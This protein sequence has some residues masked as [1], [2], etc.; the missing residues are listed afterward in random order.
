MNTAQLLRGALAALMLTGLVVGWSIAGAMA[1]DGAARIA[2]ASVNESILYSG[3][4]DSPDE[5]RENVGLAIAPVPLDVDGLDLAK[6]GLGSY[7]VNAIGGCNECHTN[8]PYAD[9]GDPFLG[10]PKQINA[11]H[12]LAGGNVFGPFVSRNITPIGPE[13]LPAG[14]TYDV[15]SD[16]MR[17][18]TDVRC[19]PGA[20]PPCPLLQ[21]MPWPVL[22]HMS[23]RD[24]AAIYEFLRAIPYATPGS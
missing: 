1:G 9:G 12:Y 19:A 2:G 18:G 20:P 3:F 22:H 17:N 8:P 6:V 10:E 14:F 7:M 5:I 15:F 4:G 21:V 23:E 24:L 11:D 13:R 16:V